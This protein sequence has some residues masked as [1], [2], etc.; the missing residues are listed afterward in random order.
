M[1]DQN[2]MV[3]AYSEKQLKA[4]IENHRAKNATDR[5]LYLAALEEYA[6]RRGKGL[7]FAKSMQVIRQAARTG[8]F[9][10]YKDLADESGAVWNTVH[11]SVG[12]HLWDLV[13]YAHRRGWPML[14]AIVVNKE[15]VATGDMKDETLAGFVSAATALGHVVDKPVDF[16]REQQRLVFAWAQATT[17]TDGTE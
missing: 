11:Y 8:H 12:Q 7:S 16:L 3:S 2:V 1:S 9:L 5:P 13:E 15:N 6:A 10:S 4:L 17:T 14:S